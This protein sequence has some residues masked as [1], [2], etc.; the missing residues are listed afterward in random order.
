MTR[1]DPEV[2][3]AGVKIDAE[4]LAELP[5]DRDGLVLE[6]WLGTLVRCYPERP[7]TIVELLDRAVA[8]F[9]ERCCLVTPE[10]T[11]SYREFAELVEGAA[12]RLRAEGLT[13]GDC[14]AV[15]LR[16][17]LEI[18]VAI[19]ACAR[20]GV[21]LVALNTRLRARQWAYMLAH[22]GARIA[23]A[24]PEFLAELRSAAAEA[25]LAPRAVRPMGDRLLGLRLAWDPRASFPDED[26][27]Y[28][29]IYTSGTTGRPKASRVVH[30]CTIH[31][32]IAYL[33]TLA[34][35]GEDRSAIT[36]PLFYITAHIAQ[37]APLMLV[38]GVCVTVAEFEASAYVRLLVEQRI[39]YLMV[40]PSVWPLLLRQPA[41]C[42]AELSHVTVG[43][44]GGSPMPRASVDALRVRMPQLRLFDAY[45]MTET[46]SPATILLDHEFRR[47][48]GSV[49]RP[50]PTCD[51]RIISDN[52]SVLAPNEPGELEL[53]GP[54]ITPGYY[55]DDTATATAII[56][57]WLRT[58][59]L[60]RIDAEGYVYLLDRKKDV[61]TRGG[62]KV[63]SLELEYLLLAHPAIEQAAVVG[64]PD[65]TGYEQVAAVIVPA[66][67]RT[68]TRREIRRHVA[69]HM[70][71]YAVPHQIR[72]VT[73]L[74]RNR[75]GKVVKTELRESL[76]RDLERDER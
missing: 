12:A 35:T 50:L 16:N 69:D 10:G 46:H 72:I 55:G 30:R 75:T 66:P 2:Q 73:E 19:W 31:S 64:L 76:L 38:G 67:G 28:A 8:R 41:F 65:R 47:K 42:A 29:V 61:I 21:I 37:I 22:S 14:I 27:T 15:C 36:F 56:D 20:A 74:P 39:T 11:V 40:V 58:G 32:A 34:L 18:A 26:A 45:G 59:D 7:R 44:F 62:F 60:A 70:A 23:L 49:G 9:P 33:R 63:Y 6:P 52:G 51:A 17:G 54:M 57:G 1:N 53:R 3:H 13:P 71:S 24:H 43:A 25:G 4:P 48:P 68:I 5:V